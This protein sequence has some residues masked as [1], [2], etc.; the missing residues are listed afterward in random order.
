MSTNVIDVPTASATSKIDPISLGQ[1]RRLVRAN[2][3]NLANLV[4]SR[5]KLPDGHAFTCHPGHNPEH[6]LTWWLSCE[7]RS[8]EGGLSIYGSRIAPDDGDVTQV[9]VEVRYFHPPM[10]ILHPNGSL[11]SYRQYSTAAQHCAH[12]WVEQGRPF[13]GAHSSL[14]DGGVFPKAFTIEELAEEIVSTLNTAL[15][16]TSHGSGPE[17]N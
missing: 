10:T 13:W 12:L 7:V 2:F 9:R 14:L 6:Q 5:V 1:A 11:Y 8:S 15:A 3:L 16:R 4:T 17:P